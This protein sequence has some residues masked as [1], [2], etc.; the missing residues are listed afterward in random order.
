MLLF[1]FLEKV[2]LDALGSKNC[3]VRWIFRISPRLPCYSFGEILQIINWQIPTGIMSHNKTL[4]YFMKCCFFILYY[5]SSFNEIKWNIFMRLQKSWSNHLIR[6]IIN[7]R[8]WRKKAIENP[9]ENEIT[10]N[11]KYSYLD[12]LQIYS[13]EIVIFIPFWRYYYFHYYCT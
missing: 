2:T 9:T 12:N 11:L 8:G 4:V 10:R 5:L 1:L 3:R 6:L 7:I 13:F